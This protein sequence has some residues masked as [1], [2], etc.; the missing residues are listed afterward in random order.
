LKGV[1]TD[2]WYNK[3]V[4]ELVPDELFDGNNRFNSISTED[5]EKSPME[6]LRELNVAGAVLK[7]MRY[8]NVD[9]RAKQRIAFASYM[10]HA[11]LAWDEAKAAGK[12]GE[13]VS[14][15]EWMKDWV[16]NLAPDAVHRSAYYAA[17]LVALDYVNVAPALDETN[18]V[19][20]G[21][22][23]VTAEVNMLRRGITPFA[24]FPYNLARQG[25]RF[26][27]D[28]LRDLLPGNA[29]VS[30]I[31]LTRGGETT[32]AQKRQA[33]ANLT[34]MGMMYLL[35]RA[36]MD[37]DDDGTPKLG[38]ELD[39]LGR[40]LE[41]AYQT[42][43]RI[44]ITDTPIGRTISA[45]LDMMGLHDLADA[46]AWMR[47]RALPYASSAV[48]LAT[49]EQAV[50]GNPA[51]QEMEAN[52]TAVLSDM[53]SEGL[54]LKMVNALRDAKGP[55]DKG[56][57]TSFMA[58]ETGFDLVTGRFIPPPLLRTVG[59]LVDPIS[60]R[61]R[62]VASLDYDPGL[63]TA[64]KMKLPGAAKDLPPSGRVVIGADGSEKS[65]AAVA[66]LLAR[67]LPEGSFRHYVDAK[68]KAKVAYVMPDKV[69][70]RPR[71]LELFRA[72]GMNVKFLD[73][74]EYAREVAALE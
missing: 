49:M 7:G 22:R 63:L 58:G 40:R 32:W 56:K 17:M 31:E 34:M 48:A 3:R 28:S 51:G 38:R 43:G 4:R 53:V 55:Y 25:K 71:V 5:F 27:F 57:N 62:P 13:G 50:K 37:D 42:S 73:R 33:V 26:T 24:K 54:L 61:S 39:D 11:R 45:A 20:M 65:E 10:A 1:I 60:R 72:F 36:M 47:I 66:E 70:V 2:R 67:E 15:G 12:V 19:M 9:A 59:A 14:K 23:D 16:Q 29:Q 21:G 74:D 52:A 30:G 44:N 69:N 8:G 46:D 18:Q 35:A 64:I 41:G 6:L 68:G